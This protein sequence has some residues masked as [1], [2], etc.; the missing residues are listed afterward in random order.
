MRSHD[1][2]DDYISHYNLVPHSSRWKGGP[3]QV[4]LNA[5][6]QDREQF[7]K[8]KSGHI[9]SPIDPELVALTAMSEFDR[10]LHHFREENKRLMRAF[11]LDIIRFRKFSI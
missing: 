2:L 1:K 9:A 7:R 8:L 3:G 11:D 10:K 5:P 4:V 6:E